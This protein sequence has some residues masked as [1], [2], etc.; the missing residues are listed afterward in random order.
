M[1]INALFQDVRSTDETCKQVMK[2][3]NK[4][5]FEKISDRVL[6][7]ADKSTWLKTVGM[8]DE[9]RK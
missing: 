6:G 8:S 4:S 9:I 3:A 7:N 5:A 2:Y 1:H